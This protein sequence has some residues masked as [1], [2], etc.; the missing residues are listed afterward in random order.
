MGTSMN[1]R[2][3]TIKLRKAVQTNIRQCLVYTSSSKYSRMNV[4]TSVV[5]SIHAKTIVYIND[6]AARRE[7]TS[8]FFIHEI[9]P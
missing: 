7:M 4:L 1:E 8:T 5:V 9:P 3:F 6:A 2:T